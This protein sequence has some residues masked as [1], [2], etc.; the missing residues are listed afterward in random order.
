MASVYQITDNGL[1]E[2]RRETKRQLTPFELEFIEGRSP[3]Y[4]LFR[5]NTIV[6]GEAGFIEL[7]ARSKLNTPAGGNKK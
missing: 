4:E 1:E 2:I 3:S 6:Q 5:P 7:L